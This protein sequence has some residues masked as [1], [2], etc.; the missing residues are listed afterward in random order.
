[1]IVENRMCNGVRRR[2]ANSAEWS[3]SSPP[4]GQNR[5]SILG[6]N[7]GLSRTQHQALDHTFGLCC[8]KLPDC[9][10]VNVLRAARLLLAPP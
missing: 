5:G 10:F 1:M 8:A 3:T 9:L 4:H 2:E 7:K 6:D